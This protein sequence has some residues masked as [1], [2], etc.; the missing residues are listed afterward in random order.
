MGIAEQHEMTAAAGMAMGGLRPGGR[1][2]LHLLL[3]GPS[4]R[5]TW[6]WACTACPVL[7]V[8]DRAGITG[9]DGPSHHGVLDLALALSIP[10]MTVFAPSSAE[11]LEAMVAT[12]LGPRGPRVHPVPATPA[13]HVAPTRWARAWRP[14]RSGRGTAPSACSGW[15]SS[16][17][18]ASRRP[19]SSV[20]RR[21]RATVWDVRV[22]CPPDPA[23]LADAAA[24]PLVV[25]AEDGVRN[26][27]AGMFLAD[28]MARLAEADAPAV[29]VLGLPRRF[30]PQGRADDILAELGL[31]GPG[32]ARSTREALSPCWRRARGRS[33]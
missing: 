24:H 22:V 19:T 4:T 31:D 17:P 11:E 13:R 14:A 25:T 9:D 30:I 29:E 21:G 6:T 12:A 18:P 27:G 33:R 15:A 2:V 3:A 28:A 16:W 8:L 26:G 1:R 7:V 10:G 5:P 20:A 23:M 32:I